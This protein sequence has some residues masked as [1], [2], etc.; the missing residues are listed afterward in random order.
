MTRIPKRFVSIHNHSGASVYDGLGPVE[1]H[2]DF[3][4]AN[5]LDGHAIT[6]HGHM[7]SYASAVLYNEKLRAKGINFK[8]LTGVEAYVH[9]DLNAWRKLKSNAESKR[10]D[11]KKRIK[12]EEKDDTQQLDVDMNNQLTVENEEASKQQKFKN[13]LN[14]RHHLVLLPKNANGLK[15]IFELVSFGYIDG[16]YRFPRIDIKEIKQVLNGDNDIIISTACLGGI[17]SYEILNIFPH[18]DWDEMTP[19]LLFNQSNWTKIKSALANCYDAYADAVGPENL[20][21][22]LQFNKLPQQDLVNQAIIRYSRETGTTKQLIVTCDAHYPGPDLWRDREIYKK[23][24]YMNYTQINPDSVPKTKDEI[25]CE[26]YPKNAT[27]IWDEY[28]ASKTRCD[29]YEDCDDLVCDAI[30]RSYDIA[31]DLLEEIEPD[32]TPKFPQAAIDPGKTAFQTLLEHSKEGLTKLGFANDQKYI[33]RL[34]EE[35]TVIKKLQVSEYFI[36]LEKMLKII[37][38]QLLT[39]TCRGSGGGSLVNYCLG[40]TDVDPVKYNLYFSRFMSLER[41]GMPDV[42]LDIEDRD[43]AIQLL[44]QEFG[45]TNVVPVSNYNLMKLKS[46]TKDLAKFYA[47][48]YEEVNEATKTVDDD[49]RKATMKDGDDKNLWQLTYDDAIKYSK[50]YREFIEKYPLIGN[51]IKSLYKELRS[52]GKHAGGCI[53]ADDLR[54]KMPLIT[55]GGEPQTPWVEGMSQKTLDKIGSW[56]KYD[57][58]GLLTLRLIHRTIELIIEKEIGKNSIFNDVKQYYEDNLHPSKI[59]FEDHHVYEYVFHAGRWA[60]IFQATQKATQKFFQ[61]CKPEN[62]TDLAAITSI[63]RPGPLSGKMHELYVDAK[64][65]K[66]YDWGSELINDTL[67]DTFG[68]L[69]FQ[70]QIMLLA[71]KVAG[72]DMTKCDQIRRAILKRS[73][74]TGEAQV[75]ESQE[76]R[77]SFEAGCVK[78]GV[79]PDVAKKLYDNILS[80]G[81]YGFNACIALNEQIFIYNDGQKQLKHVQDVKKGDIVKSRNELTRKDIFVKVKDIHFNGQKKLYK[82]KL[83]T[84]EEIRCTLDHKFRTLETGEMLPLWKILKKKLS[85]TIEDQ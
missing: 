68:L 53:V 62:V 40:I 1:T 16:F 10:D 79:T 63:W 76:L 46:L 69:I 66:P 47:I 17:F 7:N 42:D 4:I 36:T 14:R 30:E 22:E 41:V 20:F 82:V 81:S 26:L 11:E 77:I 57:L 60:G 64:F 51:S 8:L 80:W 35:L 50:S 48:S 6:E 75:K 38:N 33:D 31:H 12:K 9:P 54:E 59:N 5:G 13:P 58:L 83:K 25:K 18:L 84:G 28:L 3:C 85:L 71:N 29:M 2:I 19:E 55:S 15:K 73:L 65:N 52:L 61:K 27:Q 67:K 49:C 45:T 70:E 43:M 56:V 23:L 74:A 32:R 44:K 34:K 21:H 78:N 24:G 37:K 72:Y 39:G